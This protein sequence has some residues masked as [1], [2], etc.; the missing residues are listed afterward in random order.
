MK[1]LLFCLVLT[2]IPVWADSSTTNSVVPMDASAKP[3]ELVAALDIRAKLKLIELQG[4]NTSQT[5]WDAIDARID[6]YQKDFGVTPKTTNNV[7]LLRQ[8]ELATAR[9]FPDSARYDTLLKKL[10]ANPLPQVAD[11]AKSQQVITD[12]LA[13]L[14]TQPMDLKYT[15]VD[16]TAVDL[17]ALRGKVVLIDFWATWCGPC[18]G[19][20]PNVVAAYQKYH[21]QGFEIV[22][23]SLD[24]DKDAMLAFTKEHGMTWPQ[25]FDGK[26][27]KNEI[28]TS[29]GINS[30][31]AMWLVDKKGMLVATNAREDLAGQVGK[32][33]QAP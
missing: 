5:D 23:V 24:Q 7:V 31:P 28:S 9:K 17:G 30:I 15:A 1:H 32:L 16:G 27:W 33:L 8:M 3:A 14:K 20:V 19:E 12:R 13:Q 21:D 10:E 22:G 26:V 2:S 29:Y 11:M 6:G 18:V 4:A 25:Y